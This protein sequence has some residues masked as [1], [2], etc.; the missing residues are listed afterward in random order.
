MSN[1]M[2]S[3]THA[4]AQNERRLAVYEKHRDVCRGYFDDEG[5]WTVPLPR[6]DPRSGPFH[7]FSF[8]QGIDEDVRLANRLI[9]QAPIDREAER[10]L[11]KFYPLIAAQL[12]NHHGPRLEPEQRDRLIDVLRQA[13]EH[14]LQRARLGGYNDNHPLLGIGGLLAGAAVRPLEPEAADT[15]TD[16]LRRMLAMLD[17]RGFMSEYTSPTYSPVSMLCLAEIVEHCPY[18]EARELAAACERRLWLEV[19]SHW[20]PATCF[21]A[22]PHSRAYQIDLVAHYHNM[23]A[24]MYLVFGGERVPINPLTHLLPYFDD[25]QIRHH[26]HDEF[27]QGAT[28]WHLASTYHVPEE[29]I[30]LAW[31]KPSPTTVIATSEFGEFPRGWPHHEPDPETPTYEFAAGDTVCT[32][33]LTDRFALGTSRREFLQGAPDTNVHLVYARKPPARSIADIATLFPVLLVGD[34]DPDRDTRLTDRGRALTLQHEGTAMSLSRPRLPWGRNRDAD[35]SR[36]IDA[37]RISL[38]L[39]CFHD[40]PEEL[41]LG[42]RVIDGFEGESTQPVPI[43]VRDHGVFFAVHPLLLTDHGRPAAI[44]TRLVNGYLD[45]QLVSYEGKPRAFTEHELCATLTGF[46]L[47][48]A[49]AETWT[50]FD[51]FCES[52]RGA[53][54]TE[55]QIRPSR[56]ETVFSRE[57]LNLAMEIS[58]LSEGIKYAAINGSLAPEDRFTVNGHPVS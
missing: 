53:Q 27:V 39:T 56:R 52:E 25:T 57:D 30:D 33:H 13:T 40:R 12:L 11:H 29:A 31:N 21:L 47:S 3:A 4:A 14:G 38:L 18:D 19:A 6:T 15:A 8:F 46:A 17:R 24:L 1:D 32:T 35:D 16:A 48:V 37:I 49:D 23:H 7:A 20:H 45:L 51:A 50:S 10:S 43:F 36:G 54:I 41:R 26:F 58:P 22:G 44:R 5:R 34:A 55:N 28:M 9:A 2:N 42:E